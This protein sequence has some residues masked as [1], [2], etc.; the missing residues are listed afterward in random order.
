MFCLT[1]GYYEL[2]ISLVTLPQEQHSVHETISACADKPQCSRFSEQ[3][4]N[5]PMTGIVQNKYTLSL[6]ILY[7][8]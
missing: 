8:G 1:Q 6:L 2:T 4:E 5:D 7:K 3:I